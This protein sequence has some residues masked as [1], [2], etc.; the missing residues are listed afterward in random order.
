MV[1]ICLF[2]AVSVLLLSLEE[3][4]E[5]V[6]WLL[7]SCPLSTIL[8]TILYLRSRPPTYLSVPGLD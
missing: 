4:E 5:L 2:F 1:G 7:D 8:S 3:E 6:D